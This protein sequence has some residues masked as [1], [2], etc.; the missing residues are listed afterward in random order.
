MANHARRHRRLLAGGTAFAL[1]SA[2]SALGVAPASAQTVS[3][4]AVCEANNTVFGRFYDLPPNENFVLFAL[5]KNGTNATTTYQ[6]IGLSTDFEGFTSSPAAPIYG[7]LP[8]EV[9]SAVYRD[10]NGNSR[11][12]ATTDDTLYQGVVTITTCPSETVASPK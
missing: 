12:D 1:A 6:G 9:R 5:L 4:T 8:L 2:W 7:P 10:L 3:S 11:W